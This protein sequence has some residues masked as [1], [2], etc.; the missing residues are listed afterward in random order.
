[1][2]RYYD[3]YN[4]ANPRCV[5]GRCIQQVHIRRDTVTTLTL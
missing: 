5:N 2:D 4:R 3:W 1:M